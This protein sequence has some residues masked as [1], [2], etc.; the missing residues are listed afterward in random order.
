M[1]SALTSGF[2]WADQPPPAGAE[3][4]PGGHNAREI[5]WEILKGRG[6]RRFQMMAS[7]PSRGYNRLLAPLAGATGNEFRRYGD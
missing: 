6:F 7:N 1:E 2:A 3:V 4:V 5:E